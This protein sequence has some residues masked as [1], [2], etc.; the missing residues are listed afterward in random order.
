MEKLT[1]VSTGTTL[2]RQ[3]MADSDLCEQSATALASLVRDGALA[4][5]GFLKQEDIPLAPFLATTS[6]RRFT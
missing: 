4:Q 3:P 1:P 6:G 5:S 2:G